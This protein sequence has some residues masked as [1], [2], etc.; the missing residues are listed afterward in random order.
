MV[1]IDT[2]S[3]Q[4]LKANLFLEDRNAPTALLFCYEDNEGKE[5]YEQLKREGHECF[6]LISISGMN[7][8]DDLSPWPMG[9]AYKGDKGYSGQAG[10]FL[11]KVMDELMPMIRGRYSINPSRLAIGGYS[12]AGLFALWSVYEREEFDA[13]ICVSGSLW[14][15]DLLPFCRA[16]QPISN[17]SY[18]YFSLGSKEPR[19]KSPIMSQVGVA[20]EEVVHRFKEIGIDTTFEWNEGG[21]FV[22]ATLRQCRGIACFLAR[23]GVN[24]SRT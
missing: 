15:E 23:E 4:G 11:H 18:A 24:S 6:N 7:W 10:M 9:P 1:I 8:S 16:N 13:L 22:E 2:L 21:H 12:L 17:L 14:F 19:T 5:I 3:F 20:T